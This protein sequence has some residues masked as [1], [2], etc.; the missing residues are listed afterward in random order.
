MVVLLIILIIAG[1]ALPR[2]VTAIQNLRSGGDMRVLASQVALAKMRAA[3]DYTQTRLRADLNANTF[4][5]DVYNSATA[6]WAIESNA[7]AVSLSKGVSFS[8]GSITSA[9]TNTQSTLGQAP[10]CA[11]VTGSGTIANTAC[12]VFNSRGIPIDST[13]A[14]YGNAALYVSDGAGAYGITVSAS[15]LI[16]SWRAD[17][18]SGTWQSR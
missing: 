5:M 11:A 2:L 14:P 13:G 9:P 10:L 15:G 18:S 3:S 17:I 16:R 1:F 8:Y 7:S 6:T 4:E 12:I